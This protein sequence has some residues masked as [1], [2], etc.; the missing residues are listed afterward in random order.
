MREVHKGKNQERKKKKKKDEKSKPEKHEVRRH[1]STPAQ[2]AAKERVQRWCVVWAIN[3]R[4]IEGVHKTTLVP[5]PEW[6]PPMLTP[7]K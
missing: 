6:T 3:S 4:D 1:D 5:A 7:D 2:R